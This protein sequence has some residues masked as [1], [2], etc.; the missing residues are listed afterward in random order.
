MNLL[1]R[2][3]YG[4][5]YLM[6]GLLISA[7]AI[8]LPAHQELE[9]LKHKR[10]SIQ[11]DLNNQSSQVLIYESFLNEAS[12][13]QS[14]LRQRLFNMQFNIKED[15]STVVVDSSSSQTPLDWLSQR[16]R[17]DRFINID[18]QNASLLTVFSE[19]RSRLF[20]FGVGAFAIFIG[21]ISRTHS[22]Q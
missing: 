12:N 14:Q 4:W 19:G 17:T 6:C 9:L 1:S 5:I 18:V 8:I 3:D 11:L 7:A 21:L 22:S 20:M 13:K 15:G 16:A 2:L 10:D